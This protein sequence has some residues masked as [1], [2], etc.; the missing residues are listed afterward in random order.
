MEKTAVIESMMVM[1]DAQGLINLL[2]QE[3]DPRLRRQMIEMLTVMDSPESD[4]YL[5]ELLESKS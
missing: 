5:F 2:G 1:D 4:E 3:T